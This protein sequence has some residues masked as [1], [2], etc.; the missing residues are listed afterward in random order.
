MELKHHTRRAAWPEAPRPGGLY[1]GASIPFAKHTG[2]LSS[3]KVQAVHAAPEVRQVQEL[4]VAQLVLQRRVGVREGVGKLVPAG[5]SAWQRCSGATQHMCGSEPH[6]WCTRSGAAGAL[7]QGCLRGRGGCDAL[8]LQVPGSM[9]SAASCTSP[10]SP[11]P[12]TAS[13]WPPS[14]PPSGPHHS[15]SRVVGVIKDEGERQVV[16]ARALG[17]LQ[18]QGGVGGWVVGLFGASRGLVGWEGAAAAARA[19]GGGRARRGKAPNHF[20]FHPPTH[21]PPTTENASAP[22]PTWGL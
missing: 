17:A 22:S 13:S 6:R 15:H 8:C 12:C 2:H 5:S 14:R 11:F 1:D 3:T 10:C 18:V 20:L 4:Q 21:P 9:R 19:G 16:A 7:D